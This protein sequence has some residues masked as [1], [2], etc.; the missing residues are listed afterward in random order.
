MLKEKKLSNQ[1]RTD[2]SDK[3]M[4][5]A[6]VELILEKGSEKTTLKEVGE[7]AGY[8]RGLAGY[9]F[10]SKSSL[11]AFVLTKLHHYWLYYL[12]GATEGKVG[13]SAINS[14]TDIHFQVLDKNYDNVKAF[15]ILWFDA[16]GDNADLKKIVTHINTERHESI[17]NWIVNDTSLS[18]SHEDAS[19]LAAQ[20][21]CIFNGIVY[22]YLLN[23]S[24]SK[25]NAEQLKSL[26]D[27]L[28]NT[29]AILL[30]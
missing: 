10:G 2:Q 6:A 4:L 12:K 8:S 15:Y 24:L 9:R 23:S 22:Q 14:C 17:I 3:L 16:L 26:H 29:M 28:N 21:N 18:K 5:A 27:N 13:L 19:V 25:S 20:Y 30:K 1:E 7:K 11:F